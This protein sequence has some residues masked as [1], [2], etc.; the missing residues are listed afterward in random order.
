MS[1]MMLCGTS[2]G[3]AQKQKGNVPLVYAVENT[4]SYLLFMPL[5]TQA[6]RL[7]RQRCPPSMPCLKSV[8]CLIL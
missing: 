5:R 7:L 6:V 4:G 1:F 2:I 3:Y 8:N